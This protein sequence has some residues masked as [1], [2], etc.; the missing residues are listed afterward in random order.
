MQGLT[1]LSIADNSLNTDELTDND[2][3]PFL[4]ETKA[5]FFQE[6]MDEVIWRA[7]RYHLRC[8]RHLKQKGGY[9]SMLLSMRSSSHRE[10]ISYQSYGHAESFTVIS[11]AKVDL[12]R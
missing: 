6:P 7:V 4:S 3:C 10:R 11:I 8:M 9:Y 5:S 12:E 1:S 2:L